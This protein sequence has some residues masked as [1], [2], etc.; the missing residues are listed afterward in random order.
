MD[1]SAN[2]RQFKDFLEL[3]NHISE[4]CFNLCVTGFNDRDL[5]EAETVCVDS[6][7]GKHVNVNHKIMSVYSEVQPVYMQRR[8][9]EMTQQVEAQQQQE[10]Q[11]QVQPQKPYC[12]QAFSGSGDGGCQQ[13]LGRVEPNFQ[14]VF[15]CKVCETRQIKVIS[16]LAYKKGVVI[17]TC[18]GCS[19]H[20]LIADNLGWFSDLDGK[21]NIEEILAAKGEEVRR[22]IS[23]SV[24]DLG[25]SLNQ[26]SNKDESKWSDNDGD[27]EMRDETD[28]QTEE[29]KEQE[30][31]KTVEETLKKMADDTTKMHSV[32]P[33]IKTNQE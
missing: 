5:T 29:V 33:S 15:T 9:D 14:L 12:N 8:I 19:K 1:I 10:Q 3:Y 13:P 26:V 21:K 24:C 31:W 27:S 16:Q 2:V 20:H 23:A 17:V 4:R 25:S 32:A 6:C 7:V 22:G 11:Q 18:E 28:L 30:V